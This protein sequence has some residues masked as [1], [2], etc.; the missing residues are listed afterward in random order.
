MAG[1]AAAVLEQDENL[2]VGVWLRRA[3]GLPASPSS[4]LLRGRKEIYLESAVLS[5]DTRIAILS[6][7]R[8]NFH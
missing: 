7:M 6:F 5:S 3:P 4:E 2:D 8:F 1:A